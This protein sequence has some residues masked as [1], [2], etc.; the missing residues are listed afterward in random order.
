MDDAEERARIH[1]GLAVLDSGKTVLGDLA[2]YGEFFQ[3]KT[4]SSATPMYCIAD[5]L[6]DTSPYAD[7]WG[8][9]L[10]FGWKRH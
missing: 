8:F 2:L 9:L 10:P 4:K 1:I 5:V 6:A 7:K 3:S